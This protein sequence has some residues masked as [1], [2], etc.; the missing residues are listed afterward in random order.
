MEIPGDAQSHGSATLRAW[1]VEISPRRAPA[2]RC[3]QVLVGMLLLLARPSMQ[4]VGWADLL[5]SHQT[6]EAGITVLTVSADAG[7]VLEPFETHGE[8]IH[9][10]GRRFTNITDTTIRGVLACPAPINGAGSAI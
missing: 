10:E 2:Y 8:E 4:A 6:D 5:L 1:V 3:F 7:A 9:I